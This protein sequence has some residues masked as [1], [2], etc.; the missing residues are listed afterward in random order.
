MAVTSQAVANEFIRLAKEQGKLLTNMQLQKL[1]FIAQGF[2]LAIFDS[3]LHV[4]NTHAWQWGPVIPKLYKSLQKYG[5]DFVTDPL[6]TTDEIIAGSDEADII[7]AVLDNYGHYSAS[8]L[9][10]LTHR[11]DTP[12]SKTWDKE[13]FSVIDNDLIKEY[14]QGLV[15]TA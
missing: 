11:R 3:P 14:Y 6:E 13:K 8:Q 10:N 15:E 5:S 9:S 2:S 7:K 4:H 12:W 1:V